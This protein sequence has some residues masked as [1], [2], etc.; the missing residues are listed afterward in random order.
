MTAVSEP[1]TK[2]AEEYGWCCYMHW[3]ESGMHVYSWEKRVPPFFSIDIYTCKAFGWGDAVRF[4]ESFFGDDLLKI[5][6]RPDGG[7]N[8]SKKFVKRHRVVGA[9]KNLEA[10]RRSR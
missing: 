6:Y 8:G 3:K 7:S 5:T 1:E 4:T 10:F 2:F 9:E